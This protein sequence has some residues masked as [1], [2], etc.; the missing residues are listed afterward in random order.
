MEKKNH[1][2]EKNINILKTKKQCLLK[3]SK[4]VNPFKIKR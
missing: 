3:G 1:E 2:I 4:H